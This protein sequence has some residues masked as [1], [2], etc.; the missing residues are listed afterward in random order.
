MPTHR[1]SWIGADAALVAEGDR[2]GSGADRPGRHLTRD[3]DP[4]PGE[5]AQVVI[6]QPFLRLGA[7]G[8]VHRRQQVRVALVQQELSGIAR[9]ELRAASDRSLRLGEVSHQQNAG[10][11]SRS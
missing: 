6:E 3:R 10:R 7:D 9:V 8:T 2:A 5:Q 4:M 1:S 11:I